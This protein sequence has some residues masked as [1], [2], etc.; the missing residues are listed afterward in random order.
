MTTGARGGIDPDLK[1]ILESIR[2]TVAGVQ[3]PGPEGVEAQPPPATPAPQTTPRPLRANLP[4][5][6]KTVEEFLAD[7]IRPQV[8]AWLAAHLPEIVQK[9]AADE[10]RRLTEG[11]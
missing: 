7:L 5:S 11:K 2:Q 10:I 8:E 1:A 4:S 3:A 9:L 6:D